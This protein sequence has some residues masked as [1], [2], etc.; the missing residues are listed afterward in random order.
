VI[1]S[2]E[3]RADPGA[4]ALGWAAAALGIGLLLARP[5]LT[6]DP[7]A[8]WLLGALYVSMAI[9]GGAL[10]RGKGPA[11]LPRPVVLGFGGAALAGAGLAVGSPLRPSV[12]AGGMA[13]TILASVAEE[14]LFRGVLYERLLRSG[15]AGPAVAVSALLF[16]LVHVPAYGPGAFWVDLGAGVLLGWQRWASGSWTVPAATHVA[17][18]LLVV[19]A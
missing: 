2:G 17:A 14:A 10:A 7:R 12:T 18:N 8:P 4:R 15:G 3:I 6:G 19:M 11:R 5:A 16:A 9:G 1:R 13:L